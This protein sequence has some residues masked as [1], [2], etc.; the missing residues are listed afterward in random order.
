MN[1]L[2]VLFA[3]PEE[4]LAV[5]EKLANSVT[6]AIEVSALELVGP[7]SV[8]IAGNYKLIFEMNE[9]RQKE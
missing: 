4:S 7:V 6:I 2:L 3:S 9:L 1:E 8:F 5:S